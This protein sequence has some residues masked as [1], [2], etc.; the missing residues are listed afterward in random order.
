MKIGFSHGKC[1]IISDFSILKWK[2]FFPLLKEK[3][4]CIFCVCMGGDIHKSEDTF[5]SLFFP[6][7]LWDAG[8][9]SG[10]QVWG[11]VLS[12]AEPPGRGTWKRHLED[13]IFFFFFWKATL[14][15]ISLGRTGC[16]DLVITGSPQGTKGLFFS[17]LR[18]FITEAGQMSAGLQHFSFL[19]R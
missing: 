2:T 4:M 1:D 17:L 7:I 13:L 5:S 9:N 12:A 16:S 8:Y 3:K 11:Q 19:I 15:G 14:T 10:H 6:S 18:N